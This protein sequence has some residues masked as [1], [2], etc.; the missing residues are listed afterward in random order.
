MHPQCTSHFGVDSVSGSI[1]VSVCK[2]TCHRVPVVFI[3][4]G[5]GLRGPRGPSRPREE[6]MG[7]W[8][9]VFVTMLHF[10]WT[11]HRQMGG[12]WA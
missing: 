1:V 11:P 9:P 8:M 6:A 5:V 2:A 3:T 10:V 12:T 7:G 4:P